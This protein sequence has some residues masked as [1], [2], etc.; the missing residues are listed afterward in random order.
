VSSS[1]EP[2]NCQSRNQKKA[3]P[4]DVSSGVTPGGRSAATAAGSAQYSIA[5]Q[6]LEWW[7]GG[8][9]ANED[10]PCGMSGTENSF[11]H[12]YVLEN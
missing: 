2:V 4:A 1:F 11:G 3:R 12:W 10:F 6:S 9:V 8:R 5:T 7:H